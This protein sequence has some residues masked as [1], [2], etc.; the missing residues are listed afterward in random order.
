MTAKEPRPKKAKKPKVQK[1]KALA[2]SQMRCFDLVEWLENVDP[3]LKQPIKNQRLIKRYANPTNLHLLKLCGPLN[4]QHHH[5]HCMTARHLEL[6]PT[7]KMEVAGGRPD[8][9]TMPKFTAS[10]KRLGAIHG[11]TIHRW[12]DGA[13]I[14]HHPLKE[15]QP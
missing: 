5:Q 2:L 7:I 12:E 10:L 13:F 1:A 6:V 15:Q 3:A 4:A 14:L 9:K 8:K 11:I